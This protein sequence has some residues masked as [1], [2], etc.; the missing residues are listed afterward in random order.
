MSRRPYWNPYAAG[1]VLGV[2]LALSFALTGHGLGASGALARLAVVPVD[3]VAPGHVARTPA[4]AEMA[5]GGRS[6]L[7]HWVVLTVLGTALGGLGSGLLGGRVR[8]ETLRGPGVSRRTRWVAA[9][10]GGLL[11]GYGAR[12]ARGCTSGQALSG[13]AVL[14][15]GSWAFMFSVF[16]AGYALAWPVRRL[17]QAPAE[18]APRGPA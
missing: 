15:A 10:V 9:L 13:G 16:G 7:D 3:A 12:I 18:E 6:P 2:V 1:A 5:G 4:L 14:A 8:W 11:V 17:W